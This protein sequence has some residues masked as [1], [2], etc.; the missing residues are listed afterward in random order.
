MFWLGR[1]YCFIKC[2]KKEVC[3]GNIFLCN[4]N[5][6]SGNCIKE[7]VLLQNVK[8]VCISRGITDE[9]TIRRPKFGNV[10]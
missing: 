10:P 2:I 6:N 5:Y 1:K 4:Q 7:D 8:R 3:L 9:T